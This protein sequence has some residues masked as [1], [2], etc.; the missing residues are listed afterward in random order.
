MLVYNKHL[1]VRSVEECFVLNMSL[2]MMVHVKY[3]TYSP[4]MCS[5]SFNTW[6][7][8]WHRTWLFHLPCC[9]W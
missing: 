4:G 6:F 1:V 9:C 5:G 7:Q 2:R 8:Y 3:V